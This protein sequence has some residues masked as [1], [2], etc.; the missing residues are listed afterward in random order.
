MEVSN[1]IIMKAVWDTLYMVS[2]S[3]FLGSVLGI[4]LG[5]L[6]V[7]TRKGHILESRI[8]FSVVSPVVNTFRSIPFIILLVAIIPFTRLIVGTSF[9]TTAAIVPLV[10]HIGPY[11]S[12][13]VEN[14]LLEVDEGI[15]EA[16][17][18][19][20]ASP[21]AII[22]RCLIP[23]AFPSLILSITTATIGLIGAT[24][25]AG[26]IGGGG[27]GDVAITYGYQRF[28]TVTMIVTVVL[29][30]VMVQAVQSLGNLFERKI[31][32]V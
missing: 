4:F 6:L 26:A 14:S 2:V 27:L 31:R 7:V 18:A 25:M 13:L 17:R 16:A 5:I 24:A 32:R 29:L 21:L 20:G 10:L 1:Q 22:R 8:I 30:V 12:R 19:M 9:G 15:I 3:L 11:I 28:N 23:E